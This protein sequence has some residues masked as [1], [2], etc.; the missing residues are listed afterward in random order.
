MSSTTTEA[1]QQ[2]AVPSRSPGVRRHIAG[3]DGIRAVAA[4]LVLLYHYWATA[5]HAELPGPVHLVVSN[6][7]VGVDIFFVISGFILFLPWARAGWTGGRIDRRRYFQNRFLRIMPA[8]WFNTLVVVVAAYPAYLL[9]VEGATR[10]AVYSTFLA[11]FAPPSVQPALLLNGVAWTLCIEVCFY[12]LLPLVARFFVRRP[13]AGGPARGPRADDA[14]QA[15]ARSPA[16]ATR[17]GLLI[18]SFRNIAGTFNE[19]AVGMAVAAVWAKFEHR[20]VELR[21]GVGAVCTVVGITGVW[22]T[23]YWGQQIVGREA[24]TTGNG[25]LGW[26]PILTMLPLVAVF[27]GLALFG[28]CFRPNLLHALPVAAA[29]RLAGRRQLRHLPLA[30][31]AGPVAHPHDVAGGLTAGPD[32]AAARRRHGA[33][34]RAGR[35][36]PDRFVEQPFLRRKDAPAAVTPAAA[37]RPPSSRPPSVLPRPGR[38]SSGPS[39]GGRPS[40][41]RPTRWSEPR[42]GEFVDAHQPAA[43]LGDRP[44]QRGVDREGLRQV[45]G[46]Q[47]LGDGERDRQDQLRR[48]RAPR[49]RRR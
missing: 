38:R 17:R 32:A 13:V 14:G 7:G 6:G 16:T 3:L 42:S 11:G 41:G 36:S 44:R 35:R 40:R 43:G 21:R 37:S 45:G 23:M 33:D 5:G 20:Q 29:D 26:I 19:F 27:S 10:I 46:R 4:G 12:L 47:A 48:A 31:A 49:P 2:G 39:P 34:P 28:I 15:R 30:P 18:T 9:T 8:F 22:A 25:P 1:P 24:Y